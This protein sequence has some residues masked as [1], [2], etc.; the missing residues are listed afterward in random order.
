MFESTAD[1]VLKVLADNDEKFSVAEKIDAVQIALPKLSRR[2]ID[3][4][5][6]DLSKEKLIVTLYGDDEI[7]ALKV[8]PYALSKI[9]TRNEIK[10]F[11]FK[12]DVL[13]IFFGY[14][15]GFISAYLTK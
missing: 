8:Q 13:K 9:T 7:I 14:V 11:N 3:S 6:A 1:K 2:Q 10:I 5:I 12:V 4:V 15:L